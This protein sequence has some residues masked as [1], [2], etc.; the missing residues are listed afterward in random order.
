[1]CLKQ[2]GQAHLLA[3]ILAVFQAASKC[4]AQSGRQMSQHAAWHQ[5]AAVQHTSGLHNPGGSAHL[6]VAAGGCTLQAPQVDA[7]DP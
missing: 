7:P 6:A 2:P 5:L 1:M 4:R 3:V